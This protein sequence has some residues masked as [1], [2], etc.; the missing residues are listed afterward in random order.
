[1]IRQELVSLII[2]LYTVHRFIDIHQFAFLSSYNTGV[3]HTVQ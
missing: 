2:D 3:S 1:M